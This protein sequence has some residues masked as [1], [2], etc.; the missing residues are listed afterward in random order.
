M[1]SVELITKLNKVIP[2]SYQIVYTKIS[3]TEVSFNW[4]VSTFK[5]TIN[6]NHIDVSGVSGSILSGSNEA[7]L[8]GKLLN[9]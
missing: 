2:Y 1:T 4:R 5:V 7:I 9:M 8:L 6:N 3:D